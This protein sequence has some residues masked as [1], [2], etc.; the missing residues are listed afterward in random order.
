MSKEDMTEDL[1]VADN[2]TENEGVSEGAEASKTYE[3]QNEGE[4]LE[5]LERLQGKQRRNTVCIFVLA[6]M[7]FGFAG[8]ELTRPEVKIPPQI[9]YSSDICK[10]SPLCCIIIN[11]FANLSRAHF[12]F[13]VCH[14]CRL[15]TLD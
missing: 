7:L 6:V 12:N 11:N 10:L 4:F 2:T 8:Y 15:L 5:S 9:D 3:N 13:F 14:K 1:K